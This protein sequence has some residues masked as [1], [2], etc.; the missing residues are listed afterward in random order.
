MTNQI[1]ESLMQ[2]AIAEVQKAKVNLNIYLMNPVGIGEHPDIMAE[3]DK[4]VGEL[5]TANGKVEILNSIVSDINAKATE[6]TQQA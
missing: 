1:I 6:T 2:T 5:A 3:A 4:L